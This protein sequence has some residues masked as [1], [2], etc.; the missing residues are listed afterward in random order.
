MLRPDLQEAEGSGLPSQS[1]A[2]RKLAA[3]ERSCSL[4]TKSACFT[5]PYSVARVASSLVADFG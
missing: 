1:E 4:L 2:T 3:T 5:F